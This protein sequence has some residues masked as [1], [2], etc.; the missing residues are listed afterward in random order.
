MDGRCVWQECLLLLLLL[1]LLL[2]P[3]IDI[4]IKPFN[5]QPN[6]S[7]LMEYEDSQ[8]TTHHH[9]ALLLRHHHSGDN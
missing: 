6:E 4:Q 1:L 7:D 5:V 8:L 9:Q 3:L 2:H